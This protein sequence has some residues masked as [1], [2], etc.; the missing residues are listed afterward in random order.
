MFDATCNNQLHGGR[1]NVSSKENFDKKNPLQLQ[2]ATEAKTSDHCSFIAATAAAPTIDLGNDNA[3]SDAE[4]SM[5]MRL[6]V[7]EVSAVV[8][9]RLKQLKCTQSEISPP[10]IKGS[11]P[12]TLASMQRRSPMVIVVELIDDW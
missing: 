5:C 7:Q 12:R 6:T 2:A 9:C 3:Q 10:D 4:F 1:C 11:S 8:D